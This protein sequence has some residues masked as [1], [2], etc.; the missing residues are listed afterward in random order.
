MQVFRK[1]KC[2]ESRPACSRCT[3]TGRI[4]DGYEATASQTA[5][6]PP[7]AQP[8]KIE[9]T[10]LE[11]RSIEFFVEKS[12]TQFAALFQDEWWNTQIL[13]LAYAE[14]SIRHALVALSMHH[15]HFISKQAE[16]ELQLATR[17]QNLAIRELLL[18]NQQSLTHLHPMT[19]FIFICIEILQG[20]HGAAIHLFKHGCKMIQELQQQRARRTSAG[21]S[22]IGASLRYL[23]TSFNRLAVQVELLIGDVSPELSLTLLGSMG[24]KPSSTQR[25]IK[26]LSDARHT[27]TNLILYSMQSILGNFE[28]RQHARSCV[29]NWL[30]SFHEFSG[31]Q[32]HSG[33]K[34]GLALLEL[35]A[36]YLLLILDTAGGETA[37][38]DFLN[39]DRNVERF[40]ELVQIAPLAIVGRATEDSPLFHLE[41]GVVP[42]LYSVIAHC[43][44]PAIRRQALNLLKTQHVQEGIWSSDL[45]SRVAQ[46]LV[47]LEEASQPIQQPSD[48]P[49]SQRITSVAV[50]MEAS[51]KRA[52]VI[53]T[54]QGHERSELIEW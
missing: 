41:L 13:Q 12:R 53:Y 39:Q 48:I 32:Q 10:S 42:L 7:V 22:D 15:E 50:H 47:E 45:T 17:Q 31:S 6:T 54:G 26:S 29:N 8:L 36:K 24:S 35:Q 38:E 5:Q 52:C 19:C 1:V 2:D 3:S 46:R 28:R 37:E 20:N 16:V 34:E 27:L 25:P 9:A 14:G 21:E 4:C 18:P 51:Q 49:A 23:E 40:R 44:H 43:R 33:A 11:I 30:D